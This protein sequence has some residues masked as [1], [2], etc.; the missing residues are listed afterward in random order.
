[1]NNNMNLNVKKNSNSNNN[2]M[3]ININ[4][5]KNNEIMQE[6]KTHPSPPSVQ[7]NPS[8]DVREH[9]S[10]CVCVRVDAKRRSFFYCFLFGNA[11]PFENESEKRERENES[12]RA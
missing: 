2:K 9:P 10:V 8:I 11:L 5:N 1:M 4:K 3:N 7:R 6:N 12:I